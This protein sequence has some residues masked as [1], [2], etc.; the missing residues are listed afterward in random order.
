[1]TLF[2]SALCG[3]FSA[4]LLV[5][6]FFL[7][8]AVYGLLPYFSGTASALVGMIIAGLEYHARKGR[9]KKRAPL[10]LILVN[11]LVGILCAALW[12]SVLLR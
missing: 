4:F 8:S 11:A 2:L 1:M 10:S 5:D 9:K 3:M 12:L 7:N 6:R